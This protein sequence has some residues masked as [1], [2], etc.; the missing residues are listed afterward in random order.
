MKSMKPFCH[1]QVDHL[2]TDVKDAHLSGFC[3]HHGQRCF[4]GDDVEDMFLWGAPCP[5]YSAPWLPGL[6]LVQ[7]VC[8]GQ[9]QGIVN[10]RHFD[11]H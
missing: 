5:P 6:M 11:F 4:A 7:A 1:S 10:T 2:F 8:E 3:L 9:K